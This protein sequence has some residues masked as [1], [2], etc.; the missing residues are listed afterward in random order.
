MHWKPQVYQKIQSDYR[1]PPPPGCPRTVYQLM[2]KCWYVCF[3]KSSLAQIY[4]LTVE[5]IG[6]LSLLFRNPDAELR[7]SFPDIQLELQRPDFKLLTW[8]AEDVA[9][10]TE[11]ARTLGAPL[12]AGEELYADIQSMYHR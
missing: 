6:F 12:E 4:R 2:I 9:G 5:G 8:T 7:P 11:Q 1:L 10:H 3:P